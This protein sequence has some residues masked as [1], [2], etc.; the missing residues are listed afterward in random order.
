[1]EHMTE[2]YVQYGWQLF[3]IAFAGIVILGILKYANVFSQIAKDK[4][5]PVYLLISVGFSFVATVVYLLAI[6]QMDILYLFA[7]TGSIYAL[8]QAMYA[9]YENTKLRDLW[10]NILA[11]II[12]LIKEKNQK[13]VEDD[14]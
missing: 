9:V 4:R 13:K 1:M 10:H 12:E 3:L 7:V 6:G 5:K 11:K 8:N 2:F 14:G